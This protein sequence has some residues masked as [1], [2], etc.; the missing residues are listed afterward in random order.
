MGSQDTARAQV[1]AGHDAALRRTAADPPR[2]TA[3]RRGTAPSSDIPARRVKRRRVINQPLSDLAVEIINEAMGND[4][5]VRVREP[6]LRAS[7]STD[8]DG[9]RA[10]RHQA[11]EEQG[12]DQAPGLC[13]LLGLK[14]LHAARSATNGGDDVRRTRPTRRPAIA[15]VPRPRRPRTRTARRS[16][17]VTTGIYNSVRQAHGAE[18]R[19]A[20]CMG[21]RAA[22]HHRRAC[23][24]L[25]LRLAA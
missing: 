9:D 22:A 24:R 18:A 25:G 23:R 1:R 20:R 6:V 13:E 2:R 10:A 16:T 14:P 19:G 17:A 5:S 12:Q 4:D 15:L 11:R 3:Q 7:R 8:R 21:H